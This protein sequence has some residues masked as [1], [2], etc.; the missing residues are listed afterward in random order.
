[1]TDNVVEIASFRQWV[2]KYLDSFSSEIGQ[3]HT[4]ID[5]FPVWIRVMV[6]WCDDTSGLGCDRENAQALAAAISELTKCLRRVLAL[7]PEN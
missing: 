3:D 4:P 6:E 1:M 5:V 2:Y 7:P